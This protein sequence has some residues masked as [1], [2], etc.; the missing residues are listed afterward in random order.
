MY[1]L[2]ILFQQPFAWQNFQ[3]GWQKFMGLAEQMPGLIRETVGDVE[4]MLYGPEIQRF[5]KIHELYFES[6]QAL[7]TALRSDAGQVAA[8]WLHEF[9]RGRFILLIVE[10]KESSPS[11]FKARTQSP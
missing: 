10:H 2:V 8:R 11:D 3:Q 7:E 9:G 4:Q 1:K 5:A 6:R